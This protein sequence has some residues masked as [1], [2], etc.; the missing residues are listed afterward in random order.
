MYRATG[1]E[2]GAGAA[3]CPQLRGELVLNYYH[4]VENVSK[5]KKT[6]RYFDLVKNGISI[7][8]ISLGMLL[9]KR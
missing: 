3:L 9:I 2:R 7:I 5:K 8:K 6:L 1:K 4:S